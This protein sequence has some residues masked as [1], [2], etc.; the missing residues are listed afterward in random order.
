MEEILKNSLLRSYHTDNV[1]LNTLITGIIITMTS[2]IF[3]QINNFKIYFKKFLLFFRFKTKRKSVLEFNCAE[4][5]SYYNGTLMKGSTSFKALLWYIKKQISE[6]Q[7]FNLRQLKEYSEESD[8]YENNDK[9]DIK[10]ILYI[11][12]QEEEFSFIDKDMGTIYITFE[13]N[14]ENINEGENRRSHITYNL[15]I[16]SKTKAL[17]SLQEYVEEIKDAYLENLNYLINKKQFIFELEGES[18]NGNL[19]FATY[20][21]DTTCSMDKI[22]F[23]KKEEILNQLNFFN[24][25]RDWYERHGKPYTLGICSYGEPGCGKT[26]FEKCVT[27]MLNRHMIKVD[28]S[29]CKNKNIANKLFFS[30]KINEFKIPYDKRIYVFS[31]VDRMSE[32]LFKEEYK[33]EKPSIAPTVNSTPVIINNKSDNNRKP[34][35]SSKDDDDQLNLHHILD[36]LDGIPERTGQIIM[37][38]TNNFEKLDPALIRPGRIDCAIHFNKCSVDNVKKL[39]E[40][41]YEEKLDLEIDDS[42]EKKWTPAEIFQICSQSKNV[43]QSILKVNEFN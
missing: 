5:K 40:D 8:S 14:Q 17:S 38:S 24:T 26:S 16:S 33:K 3:S 15:L 25:K 29:K 19:E 20:P 12:N 7:I 39:I 31:E 23:D 27:K 37:M 2:Y 35:I 22:Y 4:T 32:I 43:K 10:E 6:K 28:L 41:Y 21:F 13:K 42:L 1:I 18:E 30:E 36:I 34:I 9:G 11:I